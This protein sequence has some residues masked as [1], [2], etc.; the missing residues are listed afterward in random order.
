VTTSVLD[1]VPV[2]QITERARQVRPGRTVLTVIAGALFGLGWVV[3]KVF[4]VL[5]LAFTWSWAA[6]G[7]GWEAAHGPSRGQQIATLTAQLDHYR[8][9][10]TRLNGGVLP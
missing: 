1:R 4:G 8:A 3:A 10:A 6:V 5:W 9:E 2:D 7:V